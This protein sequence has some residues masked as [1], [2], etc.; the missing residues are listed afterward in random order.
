MLAIKN[1][2]NG[3]SLLEILISVAILSIT[4]LTFASI[5]ISSL[6]AVRDG[7]VKKIVTETGNEFIVQLNTDMALQKTNTGRTEVLNAY[8]TDNWNLTTTDCPLPESSPLLTDCLSE[9]NLSDVTQCSKTERINLDVINFQCDL[10]Q[11][12]PSAKSQFVKC[13]SSTEL[14]CLLISWNKEDND[15]DN[16]KEYDSDC[17]IFEVLP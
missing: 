13:G 10:I 12:I 14:H 17:I 7:F 8:L 3:T 4:V 5:Q 16:C 2:I 6:E 11:N 9:D 15:Y 1:K